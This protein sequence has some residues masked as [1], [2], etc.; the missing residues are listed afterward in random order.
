MAS[1]NVSIPTDCLTYISHGGV[2][3]FGEKK[4]KVEKVRKRKVNK[5]QRLP[6]HWQWNNKKEY[7]AWWYKQNREV[8]KKEVLRKYHEKKKIVSKNVP[9]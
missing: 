4:E 5:G 1:T 8:Y 9:S 3:E 7:Q 6:N 2:P